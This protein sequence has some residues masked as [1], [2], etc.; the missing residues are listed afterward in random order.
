MI[1]TL[2]PH[3][4]LI[5]EGQSIYTVELIEAVGDYRYVLYTSPTGWKITKDK[6]FTSEYS[7]AY[8][9]DNTQYA[10]VTEAYAN[11]DSLVWKGI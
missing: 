7:E 10:S 5:R 4:T 6:K 11:V 8:Y 2:N 1:K 3:I 9:V